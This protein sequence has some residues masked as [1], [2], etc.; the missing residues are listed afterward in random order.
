MKKKK[1]ASMKKRI[2]WLMVLFLVLGFIPITGQVVNV[3][4]RQHEQ[5]QSDA[6]EQQTRNTVISPQRG[7]IYDTNLKPLAESATVETC[8][9]SPVTIPEDQKRLVAQK[10]SQILGVDY[11]KTYEQ[12]LKTNQ[13]EVVKKKLEKEDADAVRAFI[14]EFNVKGVH[15]AEDT[16]RYYPYGDFLA[17]VLGFTGTDNQGLYGLE[18]QYDD[19]LT[20]TRG[21]V[22]TAKDAAGN[23]LPF[24]YEDYE[25]AQS[26]TSIVLTI[27][28][29]IQ[30]V[31]EKY[32]EEAV[33]QNAVADRGVA[34]VVDVETGA[35]LAMAV[36]PDFDPNNPYTLD[37]STQ[38]RIDNIVDDEARSAARN[39]A[40]QYMWSNKAVTDTYYPGSVFKIFTAAMGLEEGVVKPDD[41]FYCSGVMQV[42]EWEIHCHVRRGHGQESFVKG[43]LN[44]CNPVFMTVAQRLGSNT[45]YKYMDAFGFLEKTGIDLPGEAVGIFHTK[46]NFNIVEL[47]TAGF[48]Q[49]FSVTP[50]QMAAGIAAVANGGKLMQP[51]IV[52][53]YVDNEKNV[54]KNVEPV[55]KR[56]II[57]KTTSDTLSYILE[58]VVTS[59]TGS[60][61]YT[62]GYRV[63]GK[64]GT[65]EKIDKQNKTG[66]ENLRIASF[67]AY[68][69]ANDP[70]IAV[71]VLLDEPG[72]PKKFGG[73]IAAPVVSKIIEESLPYLGVEPQYTESELQSLDITVP[74][75]IDG[76]ANVS[77]AKAYLADNGIRCRIIGNG[78]T[79]TNQMPRP[80]TR[81]PQ[82]GM[83]ILY[84][85]GDA[86][87]NEVEVPNVSG[88]SPYN[89]NAM[90]TNRSLN[91]SATGVY[92][93][94]G[95]VAVNQSPAAG[96]VVPLGTIVTVE[97]REP[98]STVE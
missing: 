38:L 36:E 27:D 69:P 14:N 13:Y 95:V 19:V 88:S 72:G 29:V 1:R 61:A 63:A 23:A 73:Q 54:I 79:V 32:L 74:N 18:L 31:A 70:K 33:L 68:A 71:L 26:G 55:E 28:E 4:I 30:H 59:G 66:L 10:L 80:N 49:N 39:E 53:Q 64:T 90:I 17:H 58:L 78:D 25:T 84:T 47:S 86:V 45:F 37:Y 42:E 21:R 11:N 50:M 57:S 56:Q 52:K 98:T 41:Q 75:M 40:L 15:L 2:V 85:N 34:I 5:L 76:F 87:M 93:K 6:V 9:L 16:K 24:Q 46:Q 43:V 7:T 22:V 44:S 67:G 51:Y 20:G 81:M 89:A 12:T 94:S 3:G 96:T 8:Y 77:D 48:G 97:F 92:N 91:F 35:V 83:I 62:K 60:N 65:T 82:D